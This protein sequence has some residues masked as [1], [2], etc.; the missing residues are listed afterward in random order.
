MKVAIDPA[1]CE[2][3]GATWAACENPANSNRPND[4][5]T[6]LNIRS[7]ARGGSTP[8]AGTTA[9]IFS[10]TNDCTTWTASNVTGFVPKELLSRI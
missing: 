1:E 3:Q 5:L 6:S 7:L 2:Q 10:S 8:Y 4:G 9:G